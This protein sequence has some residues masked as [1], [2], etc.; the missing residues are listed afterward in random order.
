MVAIETS[1]DEVSPETE[2]ED[3]EEEEEEEEDEE[4]E[5]EQDN[6]EEGFPFF[7]GDWKKCRKKLQSLSTVNYT[8]CSTLYEAFKTAAPMAL[9]YKTA[10]LTDHK[11]Y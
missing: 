9:R 5:E 10:S 8:V 1:E 7:T 3:E 11:F 4:E 6:E 2:E